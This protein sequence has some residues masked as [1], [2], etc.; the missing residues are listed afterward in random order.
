[1]TF[2]HRFALALLAAVHHA[3][4]NTQDIA[5]SAVSFRNGAITLSGTLYQ[6]AG[7]GPH[8]A[9]VVIHSADG[10]TRDFHAYAHLTTIL[11][12]AG[13]AV[14]LFDRRGSGGSTGRFESASFADLAG[15]AL[16]GIQYLRVRPDIDPRRVGVWGISQG[17]WLAPL[18]AATS[19]SVAFVVAVSASG[20]SPA[21]QMD[22]SAVHA[23]HEAG[24]SDSV[25]ELALRARSALNAYY[26]G[27]RTRAQVQPVIDSVL[28]QPWVASVF[29][30]N[31]GRLPEHPEGSKWA[32]TMDYDPLPVLARVRVPMAFFF[33][34]NDAWVPVEPSI[35]N[36][37][38]A[39]A[40]NHR[41][42][43]RVI[44]GADHYMETGSPSSGGQT[45]SAY[46]ES[47]IQ[48]LGAL[49]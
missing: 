16:A 40:A 5:S 15:D 33:A 4:Q 8:P 12:R 23:L 22:Y 28:G 13:F 32:L 38:G 24:Q 48:W 3:P 49:R 44:H 21:R 47:L 10:P 31:S 45:S 43:I 1:V 34:E 11:P 29:L 37:T 19:V 20:V 30:P 9:V 41:V 25:V 39:T 27:L 46:E 36:I 14:L 6:P 2:V 26:H 17:G 7:P 35:R 42:A 18:A